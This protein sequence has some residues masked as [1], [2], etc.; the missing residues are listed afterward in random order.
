MGVLTTLCFLFVSF[1]KCC[2]FTLFL[3]SP[4]SYYTLFYSLFF[5]FCFRLH[6]SSSL[7]S[8]IYI[9][10]SGRAMYHNLL[11]SL[12]PRG[13]DSMPDQFTRISGGLEALDNVFL[14]IFRSSRVV[15]TIPQLPMFQFSPPNTGR[16]T[17]FLVFTYASYSTDS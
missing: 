11:A 5:P 17:A 3:F 15:I 16:H 2:N 14:R 4:L 9:A 6:S 1:H 10:S 8:Y 13:P 7:L 12:F